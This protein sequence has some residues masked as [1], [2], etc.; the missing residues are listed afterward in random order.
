MKILVTDGNNRAA[1]AV[2]RSLGKLGYEIIV[3]E[4]YQPSL[5]STSKYCSKNFTYPD[6]YNDSSKF[7]D[8]ISIA[9]S[10]NKI[11]EIASRLEKA[12]C[13]SSANWGYFL[14][15][16]LLLFRPVWTISIQS[17]IMRALL[18]SFIIFT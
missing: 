3:G 17:P 1:L 9:I 8:S 12:E 10:E 4:Q 11:E 15:Q 18:F 13:N 7:I 16:S 6:P 5:A 14:A 2:T